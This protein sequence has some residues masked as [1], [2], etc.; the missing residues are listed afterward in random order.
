MNSAKLNRVRKKEINLFPKTDIYYGVDISEEF[1]THLQQYDFD[2]V[3]VISDSNIHDIHGKV[4]FDNIINAGIPACMH[5]LESGEDYKSMAGLSALCDTLLREGITKDSIL[6][7]LGGGVTGNIT[8]LAAAL[9][10]RGIRYIE[11]PTTLMGMTDSTLSNKQAVNGAT[12]KNQIG[13]FYPP[14]F[15]WSDMRY[16]STESR[17]FRLAAVT[18][19]IKNALIS[20]AELLSYFTSKNFD[21]GSPDV[22]D[23]L[24]LFEVIT[25][26]KNKILASDPTEKAYAVI[27]EYGH[28]FGHAIEYLT[29]GKIIHGEAVASG[30]CMAAEVSYKLG[31]LSDR[32][33]DMHY[34]L[35]KDHFCK[36][37]ADMDISSLITP[38]KILDQIKNDNKKT[39]RGVRYV[40]LE[41]TGSCLNPDGDY[42]V[43]AS[44]DVILE[45]IRLYYQNMRKMNVG[46]TDVYVGI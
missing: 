2:K 36:N 14:L 25:E 41:K 6:I 39:G 18:E 29:H 28:T 38:G 31:Y 42:Q 35:L 30:M 37:M 46:G 4:F 44:D 9:I 10:Y 26:S 22:Y 21:P 40:L 3:Y 7:S 20:D 13:T 12:G 43:E 5:L 8:G 33:A 27:L 34:E 15:V 45:C 24:W 16:A 23:L 19:G 32:E 1:L 17:R 11:V